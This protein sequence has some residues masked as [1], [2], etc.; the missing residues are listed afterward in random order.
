MTD[1]LRLH[2]GHIADTSRIRRAYIA[3]TSRARRAIFLL[4]T[5]IRIDL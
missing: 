4:P 3:D 1:A 2:R 5:E